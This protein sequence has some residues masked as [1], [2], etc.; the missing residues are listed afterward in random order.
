MNTM[1]KKKVVTPKMAEEWLK[2]NKSNRPI[3]KN[4][5]TFLA[6]Q[7]ASGSWM[8]DTGETIK[9]DKGG[10]LI[11]GQ[12]RLSAVVQ[13]KK[14]VELEV[15]ENMDKRVM[16]VIDTGKSRSSTDL[17]AMAGFISAAKL[18][19]AAKFILLFKLGKYSDATTGTV[20]GARTVNVSNQD[21]LK[22]VKQNQDELH[23]IINKAQLYYLKFRYLPQSQL[24]GLYYTFMHIDKKRAEDFFDKLSIGANLNSDNPIF[25]LRERLLRDSTQKRKMSMRE[26]VALVVVSWNY[27]RQNKKINALVFTS[28]MAFPKPI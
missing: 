23:K 18:A 15:K 3:R 16:E 9:F 17:L 27:Y 24:S 11:D 7:M 2:K 20:A 28:K 13:A 8:S 22:F 5:V 19:A 6:Q 4:W 21:I 26:K 14:S 10:N 12:H 1:I 25:L